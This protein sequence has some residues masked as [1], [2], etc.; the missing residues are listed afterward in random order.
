MNVLDNI[1]SGF[2]VGCR[3]DR[4]IQAWLE[5]DTGA[6]WHKIVSGLEE[7]EM[8]VL[9]KEIATKKCLSVAPASVEADQS[10]HQMTPLTPSPVTTAP[11]LNDHTQSSTVTDHAPPSTL[12][13]HTQPSTVTDHAQPSTVTDH[14]PPSTLTDHAQSS[15]ISDH[16][17]PSTVTFWSVEKVKVTILQ[18]KKRFADLTADAEDELGE[19]EKQ[20][21]RFL[22]R[23]RRYL[24]LLPVAKKVTH[25]KFFQE[26]AALISA[27][28]NTSKILDILCRYIDYRNYEILLQLITSY[29]AAPLQ[30]SMRQ[31]CQSLE[32]F[33]KATPIDIYL[34]AIPDE[35]NEEL[36]NAFSKMVVRIDK[37]AS[38]CT[39]Y[40]IRKL[41]EAIIQGSSLCFHSVYIGGVADKCVEV[42]VAFPSSAVGWVLSAM[43]PAFMH[44]HLLSEVA[45][46]GRQLTIIE[47]DS[48][49]LVS[50][51]FMLCPMMVCSS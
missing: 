18:L 51:Y 7:I 40:D 8:N 41:N 42:V 26:N 12:T 25:V 17:Q 33:E 5:R 31:Y 2:P 35:A 38:E 49:E 19:L 23:F 28:E 24:L 6:S 13:D 32:G 46:D 34:A 43:T 22:K 4:Y 50:G 9:A 47:A 39:L 45:V 21:K 10:S 30:E 20:D 36:G 44:T 29:C 14:A 3:S 16:A 27:A 37:P 11:T 15:T 48:D 1:D